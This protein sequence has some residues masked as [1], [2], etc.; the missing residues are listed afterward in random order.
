MNGLLLS[1][2]ILSAVLNEIESSSSETN[3]TIKDNNSQTTVS[4]QEAYSQA[5][6]PITLPNTTGST[7]AATTTTTTAT[8]T[9]KVPASIT[10]D[11]LDPIEKFLKGKYREIS[12]ITAGLIL[13][14]TILLVA[15][16]LL[17][18]KVCKLNRRIKALSSDIELTSNTERYLGSAK[19][20]KDKS[21]VT[22]VKETSML[23][24]DV[25]QAQEE[26]ANGTTKEEGGTVKEDGQM[27]KENK[28][29]EEGDAAKSEDVSATP[30]TVAED[31]ST[32]KPQEEAADAESSKAVAASSSEG[33]EEPKDVV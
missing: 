11:P 5:P 28:K 29:E 9:K 20:D 12:F 33:T 17:A 1:F 23:M 10:S 19:R 26:M 18:C 25:S 16:L 15:T 7:K 32:S 27:G 3:A 8:T 6:K 2:C 21:E 22:E 30:A 24:A 13:A 14:C 4:N 31:A